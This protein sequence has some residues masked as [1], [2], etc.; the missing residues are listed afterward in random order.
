M[1]SATRIS[2]PGD[3]VAMVADAYGDPAAP[4]VC[5]F[6]HSTFMMLGSRWTPSVTINAER[7]GTV[8]TT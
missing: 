8:P 5:F 6:T 7:S 3:G 2:L 4:P 1:M